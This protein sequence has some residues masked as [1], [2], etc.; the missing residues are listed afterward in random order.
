MAAG[1]T[2]YFGQVVQV[3]LNNLPHLTPAQ[4]ARLRRFLAEE[5]RP[6]A[7]VFLLHDAAA[8]YYWDMLLRD[9]LGAAPRR[10]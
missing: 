6:D 2:P 9:L 4:R 1:F 3:S 7:T 5:V 10:G 8:T